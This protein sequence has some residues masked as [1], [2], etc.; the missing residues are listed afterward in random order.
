DPQ[1]LIAE[2]PW[3]AEVIDEAVGCARKA[4]ASWRRTNLSTRAE[5]LRRYAKALE[6][7]QERLA[8]MISREMGKVLWEARSEVALMMNKV[9]VTLDEGLRL[10]ADMQPEGLKGWLRYRPR[11]VMV[12]IGPFNFPGHLPNGHIV[13]A[14]ATGNT[15]VF[16]PA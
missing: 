8:P 2:I 10:I 9:K 5:I 11:G 3:R 14:L 6:K 16:K 15:V 7:N 4:F 12:V 1:D 13:P